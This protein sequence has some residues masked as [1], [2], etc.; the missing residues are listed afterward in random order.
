MNQAVSSPGSIA[1]R[2][3][4]MLR[5]Y[6]ELELPKLVALSSYVLFVLHGFD[7]DLVQIA[8]GLSLLAFV[9]DRQL[10]LCWWFW[11]PIALTSSFALWQTWENTGNHMYLITY[12]TWVMTAA[13]VLPHQAGHVI[14]VNARFLVVF[15][16]LVAVF[17]KIMSSTYLSGEAFEMQLLHANRFRDFSAIFGIPGETLALARDQIDFLRSPAFDVEGNQVL[18]PSDDHVKRLAFWLTW[19]DL[20]VQFLIGAAFLVRRRAFDIIG[21]AALLG[22]IVTTYFWVQITAFGWLITLLGLTLARQNMRGLDVVY[23]GCLALLVVF[24][25]PL[26]SLVTRFL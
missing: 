3:R 2:V 4:F 22:F 20:V 5:H 18:I 15:I 21:H 6:Q 24:Q 10:I 12:W 19:Y 14:T 25:V 7:H 16:F 17:Q 13:L 26:A 1:E 23:M 8:A 11:A 9:L